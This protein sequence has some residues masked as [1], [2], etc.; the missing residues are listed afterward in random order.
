VAGRAR[1]E[2]RARA[3]RVAVIRAGRPAVRALRLNGQELDEGRALYDRR[4]ELVVEEEDRVELVF[5]VGR[6]KLARDRLRLLEGER[7]E[8][9]RVV[10]ARLDLPRAAEVAALPTDGRDL[11]LLV[12]AR[13]LP[14]EAVG[15]PGA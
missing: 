13:V 3:R 1:G 8:D 4:D 6:A 12:G 10:L 15:E 5:L 9:A 7:L 2:C 14:Q 11:D